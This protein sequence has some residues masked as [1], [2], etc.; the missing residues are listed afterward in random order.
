MM[1]FKNATQSPYRYPWGI[2]SYSS[3]IVRRDRSGSEA[4]SCR[5]GLIRSVGGWN[6][7]GEYRKSGTRIKGDE[8]ILGSSCFVEGVLKGDGK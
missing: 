8:R 2:T 5:R 7:L 4:G 3:P 1:K 6:A